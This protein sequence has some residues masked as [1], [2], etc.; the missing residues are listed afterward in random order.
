MFVYGKY[1][2]FYQV[3]G[4]RRETIFFFNVT[5]PVA[6]SSK[7]LCDRSTATDFMFANYAINLRDEAHAMQKV[8]DGIIARP[9]PK[10]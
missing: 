5:S 6:Y 8:W 3:W 4:L 7:G 2:V 10:F 1:N 9:Y